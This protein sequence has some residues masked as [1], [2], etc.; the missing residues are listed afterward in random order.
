MGDQCGGSS[1]GGGRG[2]R[3]R[4]SRIDRGAKIR[5]NYID[6]GFD[7]GFDEDDLE[8]CAEQCRNLT[9][10]NSYRNVKDGEPLSDDFF[11]SCLKK[12]DSRRRLQ[13]SSNDATNKEDGLNHP[14]MHAAFRR[15]NAKR[16]RLNSANF[17]TPLNETRDVVEEMYNL[18]KNCEL[19]WMHNVSRLFAAKDVADPSKTEGTFNFRSSV[20][21][22]VS[23]KSGSG[24]L[25]GYTTRSMVD[26]GFVSFWN[27]FM[28]ETKV[29]L[30]VSPPVRAKYFGH[31]G[32]DKMM[33]SCNELK[34]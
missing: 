14:S 3:R 4:A 8:K 29:G 24:F 23:S 33:A 19:G 25:G 18:K 34:P 7:Y 6:G 10:A 1:S 21:E 12:D 27:S 20:A 32:M 26:K 28:R 31:T 16:R 13:S 17:W 2:R 9:L 5:E 22:A 11:A 15:L 30:L